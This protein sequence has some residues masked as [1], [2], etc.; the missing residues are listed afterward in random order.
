M[1]K[2]P[3]EDKD[4]SPICVQRC[5]GSCCDPWWG[6]IHYSLIT[7]YDGANE[8]ALINELI[9]GMKKREK[10]IREAYVTK[11]SPPRPLFNR[12]ETYNL[13]VQNITPHGQALK[14]DL[15]AMFAFR[16]AFLSEDKTCIVHPAASGG[17][18]IRPPHCARLGTPAARPGQEGYCRII[19]AAVRAGE[20]GNAEEQIDEAIALERETT[21]KYMAEG[22]VDPATAAERAVEKVRAYL[23]EHPERGPAQPGA[24]RPG[25][26]EPC[27]CG[28]GKKYKK[29]HGR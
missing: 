26:N 17:R 21:R 29:C 13:L 12:P 16:C 9:R 23:R 5:Q 1:K 22:A 27:P 4:Y 14:L 18:D 2:S 25:R 19:C 20:A 15:I 8:L 11:E 7:R 3:E 28:S 10:R 24:R 6:I